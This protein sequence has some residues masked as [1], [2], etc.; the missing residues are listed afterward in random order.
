MAVRFFGQF[1]LARGVIDREQLLAALALQDERNLPVGSYAVRKGYLS[2]EQ[3]ERINQAQRAT[4][5]RFG[6]LAVD[7]GLLTR[8]QVMELLTLQENDHVRIGE[9]LVELGYMDAET[10]EREVDAFE[11]DQAP[12]RTEKRVFPPGTSNPDL[13]AVIVDLTRKMLV[14]I[15][16]LQN[17]IAAIEELGHMPA[18]DLITVSLTF[19]GTLNAEFV[20]SV[21]ADVADHVAKSLIGSEEPI[22]REVAV[23]A[24]KEL[25]N[26]ICGN[27]VGKAAQTGKR[28]EISPP[29]E[30]APMVREGDRGVFVPLL[31]AHG[32]VEIRIA[33]EI[34][35]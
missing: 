17:K 34:V 8:A 12:Y 35:A 29:L 4:D 28:V 1:L 11:R 21:S 26:V 15:T 33:C 6:D 10:L 24:V 16:R 18:D 7:I 32:V 2:S 25:A 20:L 31:V 27:T 5:E 14:R 9:A 22:A 19:T 3:A 30:G 13:I 23:D